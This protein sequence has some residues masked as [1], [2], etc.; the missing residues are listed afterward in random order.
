VCGSMGGGEERRA[1]DSFEGFLFENTLSIWRVGDILVGEDGGVGER[2]E[3]L[4]IE[5][6]ME[7]E[8][9]VDDDEVDDDEVDEV[10]AEVEEEHKVRVVFSFL[11]GDNVFS[12]GDNISLPSEGSGREE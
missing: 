4:V 6:E 1:V 9:D 8:V 3:V 2:E 5:D 12:T 10:E 7:D 11:R